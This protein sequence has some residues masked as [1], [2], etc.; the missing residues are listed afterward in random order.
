M[1][2]SPN[3]ESPKPR[4]M[5]SRLRQMKALAFRL[6][7]LL[8]TARA[9]ANLTESTRAIGMFGDKSEP[10]AAVEPLWLDTFITVVSRLS[11]L[12]DHGKWRP[13]ILGDDAEAS[14]RTELAAKWGPDGAYL[15]QGKRLLHV[16]N[17][18]LADYVATFDET[19]GTSH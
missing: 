9:G 10:C 3:T 17:T 13:S 19:T 5:P 12:C 11:T 8:E 2:A 18:L 7:V 14:D 16:A 6:S 15:D 1:Q 4:P